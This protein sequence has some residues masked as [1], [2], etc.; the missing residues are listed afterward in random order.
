MCET[1]KLK[2]WTFGLPPGRK[3]QWCS[4][5]AKGHAGAVEV[6]D[7]KCADCKRCKLMA[8]T[9]GLMSEI[10]KLGG[11]GRRRWSTACA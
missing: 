3:P 6:V 4:G 7:K 5:C 10:G 9:F 11:F 8:P 2:R 1:C